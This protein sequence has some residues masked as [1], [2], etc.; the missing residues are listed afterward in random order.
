MSVLA[1]EK[2][3]GYENSF[4][5]L[6]PHG[7]LG[8]AFAMPLR[9]TLRTIE[10]ISHIGTSVTQIWTSSSGNARLMQDTRPNWES[11]SMRLEGQVLASWLRV[12]SRGCRV[13]HC[14]EVHSGVDEPRYKRK[15]LCHNF[16]SLSIPSLPTI[17]NEILPPLPRR[18]SPN[19]R[20]TFHSPVPNLARLR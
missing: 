10:Q 12:F 3:T 7:C 8:H 13:Q 18:G 19:G 5:T 17:H 14:Q 6:S 4:L 9:S 1:S 16:F 2:K 20:G 11:V 15:S